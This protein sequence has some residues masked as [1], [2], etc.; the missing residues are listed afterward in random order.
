MDDV[1]VRYI[2]FIGIILLASMLVTENVLMSRKLDGG[3]LK[4]LV[5]I[6][7]LYGLGAIITFSAGLALWLWVGKPKAFYSANPVFHAKMGAFVLMALLSILPTLFI[8]RNRNKINEVID[9]PVYILVIK[10][11]EL[12]FLL[13]IPLL[14]VLMA[15]GIGS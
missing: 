13:A 11:V 15:R 9:I 3:N 6:D 1:F 14:A 5:R 8:M 2:H 7:S 12:A 4:K 10:R